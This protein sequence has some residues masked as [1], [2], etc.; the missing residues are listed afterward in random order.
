MKKNTGFTL[1]EVIAAMVILGL[2]AM[3]GVMGIGQ[4]IQG[5]VFTEEAV[6]TTQMVQ[7]TLERMSI[8]LTHMHYNPPANTEPPPDVSSVSNPRNDPALAVGYAVGNGSSGTN[9]SFSAL[10][11]PVTM[12]STPTLTAVAYT[13]NGTTE[14]LSVDGRV[15]CTGVTNF[16]L[17]YYTGFD[18]T[19]PATSFDT[20]LPGGTKM[21][22]IEIT[23]NIDGNPR[24]FET[25]VV[26]QYAQ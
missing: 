11:D 22:G 5:F 1:I 4:A 9:I 10:F 23:V 12:T 18:D 7:A 20:G 16:A 2:V 24:L 25:R 3:A 26:P 15:L 6:N 13:Y 8:D 21:I 17:R 19:T 14:E